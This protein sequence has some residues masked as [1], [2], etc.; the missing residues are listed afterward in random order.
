MR[1]NPRSSLTATPNMPTLF[2]D[3]SPNKASH[4]DQPTACSP[5]CRHALVFLGHPRYGYGDEPAPRRVGNLGP[6]VLFS[7][8]ISVASP[9][10]STIVGNSSTDRLNWKANASSFF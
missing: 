9:A 6:Q 7:E 1:A 8:G 10:P 2:D 5:T 3:R 4:S